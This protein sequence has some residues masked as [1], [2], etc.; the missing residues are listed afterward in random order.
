MRK[1]LSALLI[2]LSLCA[3]LGLPVG[4][5][6]QEQKQRKE[7][8][9][10]HH[11]YQLI[12]MGTFGGPNSY[13]ESVPPE[14][15]INLRGA[16]AAYA[17]TSLPD[18]YSPNCFNGDCLV[19]H[20]FVWQGGVLTDLGSL[21]GGY[22]S[23]A[24]SINAPGEIVGASQNGKI[25]P[26]TA[27]PE[28]IAVLWKNGIINLGTLG[29]NQSVADA[30]NDRGQV[31]GAAL[32]AI[33][34]PLSN[35][36]S[37][38]FLFEP[39]A[40]QAHAFLWTEAGG[41]QDL[42]TLGGPDSSADFVNE[43]GQIAGE[44]YT[45][46]T[47]NPTTE[48]PTL[49][50][51]FWENGKMMDIGTLGGTFGHPNWM[52]NRGQVVGYSNLAGDQAKHAFLWGKKEG[53]K[54]LGT[55]E[56]YSVSAYANWI[57][58]AGEI[59]GESKSPT[60]SRAFLWKN[61]AMTDL[62]TVA[63]DTCS[64][65]KSINSQG[66]IVGFGSADCYNEDHGF[67][68][69]NGGPIID[70]NTLV[71]PGSEVTLI[72]AI[73]IND[74]GEIAGW[75]V[76]PNGDGRA[77][78]LI[79]CDENHPDVEG[80]DYDPIEPV[81]EVQVEPAQITPAPAASPASLSRAETMTRSRAFPQRGTG[82]VVELAPT[83]LYFTCTPIYTFC[84]GGGSQAVTLTNAGATTLIISGITATVPFYQ[85]NN[86]GTSLRAGQSCTFYVSWASSFGSF[87]G[88]LSVSDNGGRSPQ[89]VSLSGRAGRDR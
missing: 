43:R 39:A 81:T 11:H 30:I 8:K 68:W 84:D 80:C 5:S 62:G 61:G 67:L 82:T 2:A 42:G 44:S 48:Q 60:A 24:S 40:T 37:L 1:N 52:N 74:R 9:K 86:C 47:I 14:K 26:L 25:D 49:D 10:E 85:Q 6:A 38:M 46:A 66:Q 76:L 33:P 17:D 88:V 58:D 19:S 70:L 55:L 71:L 73:F 79:P 32:N 21:P 23:F 83:H 41:M 57:N 7:Q 54:D 12:D 63:G 29:G 64:A 36:F 15:I 4:L 34:D 65:A 53:L 13:N 22:N 78:V 75:G 72:N 16:A 3:A 27:N 51:F 35:G 45:N 56:G 31:V 87:S 28:A 69:E 50:P 18:P 59:V 77:V 20:A 89:T